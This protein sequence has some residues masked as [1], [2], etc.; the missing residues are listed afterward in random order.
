MSPNAKVR[1]LGLVGILLCFPA[2]VTGS[3][4][5]SFI[6]LV[7]IGAYWMAIWALWSPGA[8]DGKVHWRGSESGEVHVGI[9]GDC[10]RWRIVIRGSE[11]A[12]GKGLQRFLDAAEE[13][14]LS[15]DRVVP[16]ISGEIRA[17]VSRLDGDDVAPEE[18]FRT[19]AE[20]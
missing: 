9:C 11:V 14:A 2:L 15:Y 16:Q 5:V 13:S 19:E 8:C 18:G 20:S 10:K 3:V 12:H 6:A 4:W 7:F 17:I 1:L